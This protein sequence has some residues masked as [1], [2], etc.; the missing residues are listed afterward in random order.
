MTKI[1]VKIET[2]ISRSYLYGLLKSQYNFEDKYNKLF[3]TIV[4]GINSELQKQFNTKL[5][6]ILWD[7]NN[8]SEVT[9][10]L[11]SDTIAEWLPKQDFAYFLIGDILG[12]SYKNNRLAYGIDICDLHPTAHANELIA[13]FL[14]EKIKSGEI[15]LNPVK[16]NPN[17][18]STA[19]KDVK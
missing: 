19:P 16:P 7:K 13:K 8:L 2:L 12:E 18:A 9:E 6:F 5:N 14:A 15:P 11:E 10:I 4:D 17:N 3:F 1:K